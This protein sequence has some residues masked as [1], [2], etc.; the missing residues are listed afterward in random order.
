MSVDSFVGPEPSPR[1]V[2]QRTPV[3]RGQ[4]TRLV[5][6]YS[7]VFSFDEIRNDVV[8]KWFAGAILLGFHVTYSSWMYSPLTTVQAIADN[9]FVCWPFFQ[10]CKGLIRLATLPEGYSQ[11]TVYMGL[12]G[13]M[14]L[15]GYLM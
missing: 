12:F 10:S 5:E 6:T 7:R 2:T 9:T 14:V 1:R 13:I 11:T 3:L 15:S 8:L 4:A